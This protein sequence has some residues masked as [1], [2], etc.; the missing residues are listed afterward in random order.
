MWAA[1]HATFCIA[2]AGMQGSGASAFNVVAMDADSMPREFSSSTGALPF[3]VRTP[4]DPPGSSA[5]LK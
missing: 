3:A 2:S 4:P 1:C 5:R